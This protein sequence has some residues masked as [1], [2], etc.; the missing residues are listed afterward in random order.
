[1]KTFLETTDAQDKLNELL[2]LHKKYV[3]DNMQ[4]VD[5][6]VADQKSRFYKFRCWLVY[7]HLDPKSKGLCIRCG[8]KLNINNPTKS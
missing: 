1:M 2:F 8:K 3:M 5:P 4:E 7:G 6:L